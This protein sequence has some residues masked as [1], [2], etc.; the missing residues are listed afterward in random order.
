MGS[1]DARR[2]GPDDEPLPPLTQRAQR[3]HRQVGSPSL[4]RLSR[5]SERAGRLV[6]KSALWKLLNGEG[7]PRAETLEGFVLACAAVARAARP[8]IR[9][10]PDDIDLAAWR[11]LRELQRRRG[12]TARRAAA[13]TTGTAGTGS[14]STIA[15]TVAAARPRPAD[16]AVT[17]TLPADSREF[18][19]RRDEVTAVLGAMA[20][21]TAGGGV[22]A[23]AIVG[24][25]GVG[26]TTLAVHLAHLAVDRF[27]DRRLFVDLHAHTPG[28]SP[29]PPET[30]LAALLVADGV[31]RAHLPEDLVG[32]VALWRNR[33]A[34]TPT[35]LVVDNAADSEHVE[36]LLPPAPGSV[37]LVTSRRHLGDLPATLL[38]V[39]MAA[40]PEAEAVEMFRRLAPGAAADHAEVARLVG[41]CGHLPLA[42]RLLAR[43]HSKHP[44]WSVR[45]LAAETAARVLQLQAEN[46]TVT[47]AFDLSYR[48]L[49]P[50]RQR[51]LRLLGLHPG[52]EFDA[53]AAAALTATPVAEARDHLDLLHGDSLLIERGYRRYGLHDLIREYARSLVTAEEAAPSLDR[54]RD[55]YGHTAAVAE[56][57]LTRQLRPASW[58]WPVPAAAPPLADYDTAMAWA[59]AELGNVR[60]CI[61]A[62]EQAADHR[63]V[64]A[65]TA[66]LTSVLRVDGHCAESITL[67]RS[68]AEA[69]LVAGDAL[70]RAH[71]LH[72]VASALHFTGDR[73]GALAA[74]AE[75]ASLYQELGDTAGHA[76]VLYDLGDDRRLTGQL[77]EAA[78]LITEALALYRSLGDTLGEARSLRL[79][80]DVRWLTGDLH[81]AEELVDQ[82]LTL[83]RELGNPLGEA[84]AQWRLGHIRAVTGDGASAVALLT[85]ALEGFRSLGFRMGEASA[86]RGLGAVLR[87]EGHLGP[88]VTNQE[89][90]LEISRALGDP[91]GEA[92]AL[93]ELGAARIRLGSPD[94]AAAALTA[95]L[96]AFR[97]L[98]DR[99]GEAEALNHLGRL[100]METG[101][102]RQ[103]MAHFSRAVVIAAESQGQLLRAQALEGCGRC[104]LALGDTADG[105]ARLEEALESYRRLGAARAS[106]VAERLRRADLAGGT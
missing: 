17:F 2:S 15:G 22:L 51:F 8:P 4:V 16:T 38:P 70:G 69:A 41:L 74:L 90:A 82:A 84:D 102:P 54:L 52:D 64:V 98:G 18:V 101:Q 49:T 103:A 99:Q 35:L 88:A 21:N 48:T 25:P 42:I 85:S 39:R 65:L 13:G 9:L 79:L 24:M 61:Q 57:L 50:Q 104:S 14:T 81:T 3:L 72:D 36:P 55:Y 37:V 5:H 89:E 68:A 30:A 95:A 29:T 105:R 73:V 33:T 26:K 23:V 76:N 11:E 43:L 106:V 78:Q 63:H 31:E 96:Q 94:E 12:A 87:Q 93:A 10:A 45:D 40:P 80:G 97:R 60:A 62:A 91:L 66:A 71:A 86:L 47:A 1:R 6:S 100:R 59:R 28:Q 34:T 83:H 32:R 75:A 67:H 44:S 20:D 7:V 46:H 27:P 53:F 56:S 77:P 92:N 19:G 58:Q